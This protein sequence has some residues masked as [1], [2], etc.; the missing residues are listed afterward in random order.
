[1][2]ALIG[3]VARGLGE[4][5]REAAV[6]CPACGDL[7]ERSIK[8]AAEPGQ[9]RGAE[10]RRFGDARP[11]HGQAEQIGQALH[12]RIIHRHAAIDVE[13]RRVA[14][15]QAHRLDQVA[16]LQ[17]DGVEGRAGDLR[18]AGVAGDA[19]DGAPRIGVPIG[20][21]EPGEGRHNGDAA[22]VG[23]A[24]GEGFDIGGRVDDAEA[25]AQPLHGG[26]GDEDATLE[27]IGA[28]AVETI[29]DRGQQAVCRGDGL[30]P[31]VRQ[32]EGAGAVGAFHHAGREA[33]LAD[34][35]CVLIARDA[36]DRHRRAQKVGRRRAEIAGA[37]L[38]LRQHRARHVEKCQQLVVPVADMDV[39]E[40]GAR[41]V[42]G[43]GR[44][45]RPA[46]EPPQEKAVDGSEG[47]RAGLGGGA[48]AGHV[49]EQPGELGCREIGV[50]DEPGLG[51]DHRLA[52]VAHQ[53]AAGL[54]GSAVLPDDRVR[55]RRARRTVPQ[56]GR[57]ALI[58]D[59]DGGEVA[60]LDLCRGERALRGRERRFPDL[61]RVVLDP[62]VGREVLRELDLMNAR[63][64]AAR[65]EHDGARTRRALVD[66]ED[67]RSGHDV[68]CVAC[69]GA[70]RD[71][72]DRKQ[73]PRRH[74]RRVS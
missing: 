36:G 67:V 39:V 17:A 13:R 24:R 42:G 59:A 35:R 60:C 21:A 66:G 40:H 50:A 10:C 25:V 22:R 26:A 69:G 71:Q 12:Q 20:R 68:E 51:L 27:R 57:L 19:E 74:A 14:A 4:R 1:M 54:G 38:D 9:A 63:D 7:V 29:G 46:G 16:A 53:R 72:N 70:Q 11:G 31:G 43:V 2:P 61:V 3:V 34:E 52:P 28:G 62:A 65:I 48:C 44:V 41:G 30:G 56:H 15:V 37:V 33:G 8:T 47:E 55:D 5:G 32:H 49:V 23:D 45:H 58:G 6:L 64:G 73:L 18:P